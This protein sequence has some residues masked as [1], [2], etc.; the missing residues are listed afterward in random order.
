VR[1][2]PSNRVLVSRN[3]KGRLSLQIGTGLDVFTA[4]GD[5][6]KIRINDG[7][8]TRFSKQLTGKRIFLPLK[9]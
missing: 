9:T 3:L 5:L 1:D 6:L 4:R 7:P 2:L 8:E